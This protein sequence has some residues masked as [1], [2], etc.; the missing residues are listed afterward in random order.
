MNMSQY[1]MEAAGTAQ[2]PVEH[3][4]LY[5]ALGI[6]GESGEYLEKLYKYARTNGKGAPVDVAGPVYDFIDA[7]KQLEILKKSIRNDGFEPGIR[8]V[9]PREE[10]ALKAAH[11]L[12]DLLWYVSQA[13]KNL[14][15][16]LGEIAAMN[17]EKLR[18]RRERGVVKGAGDNR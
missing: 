11:E 2:Y 18:S 9:V 13:A 14:G 4:L 5:T 6:A 3:Q 15:F 17:L 8:I 16:T 1:Q 7:A 12:G 10:D